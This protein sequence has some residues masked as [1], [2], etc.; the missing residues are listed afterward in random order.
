MSSLES[1]GHKAGLGGFLVLEED[2]VTEEHL[3]L[4]HDCTPDQRHP[5]GDMGYTTP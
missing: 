4:V 5:G 3:R 1:D 2:K